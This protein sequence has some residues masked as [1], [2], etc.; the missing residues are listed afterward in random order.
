MTAPLQLGVF[1]D[2]LGYR[3]VNTQLLELALT[4]ASTGGNTNYERLEFLGDRVLGLVV[5][6]LLY[7]TFPGEHEGA[8]AK[9]HAALVCTETL[10]QVAQELD[11]SELVIASH[12]ERSSGGAAQENLLADCMEAIIGAA[13]LD[14]GLA[15]CADIIG[16]LWGERIHKLS[17]PPMDPKTGL[18]EWAQ[19]RRLPIPV[20]EVTGKDGPD[21]SPIFHVTVSLRG[22]DPV[23]ASGPSRRA[24]EKIAAQNLLEKLS[25]YD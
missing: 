16:G 22:F 3:F 7:K 14:N 20:Y 6:D 25:A 23:S 11:L 12:G 8:L 15:P 2:R 4:H 24:A 9:R 1:Q 19:A 13:Y 18:Q 17:Q 10:A 21:H 5:A